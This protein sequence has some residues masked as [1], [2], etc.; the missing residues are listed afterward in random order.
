MSPTNP[1]ISSL[2]FDTLRLARYLKG[3]PIADMAPLLDYIVFM[4]YD[5]RGQWDWGNQFATEGCPGGDCL[6]SQ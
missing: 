3:F 6:R 2:P 5:L 1:S 4:T